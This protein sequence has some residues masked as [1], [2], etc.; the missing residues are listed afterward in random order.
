MP[1]TCSRLSLANSV[2]SR[3]AAGT[4][5]NAAGL[6][7]AQALLL[8]A[9]VDSDPGDEDRHHGGHQCVGRH[10]EG[11]VGTERHRVMPPVGLLASSANCGRAG[12]KSRSASPPGAA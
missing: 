4:P 2:N 9:I 3:A 5:D 12:A 10:D 7:F 8:A 6:E 11:G 1:T